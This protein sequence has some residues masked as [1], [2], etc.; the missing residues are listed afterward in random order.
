MKNDRLETALWGCY[1]SLVILVYIAFFQ[2]SAVVVVVVVVE[3]AAPNVNPRVTL[4]SASTLSGPV[5]RTLMGGEGLPNMFCLVASSL[6]R[7]RSQCS[8]RLRL[9]FAKGTKG[10]CGGVE[11]IGVG[12]QQWCVA[13]SRARQ[14]DRV[15]LVASGRAIFGPGETTI[16]LRCPRVCW[17]W[18]CKRPADEGSR[19][20]LHRRWA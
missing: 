16:H 11:E 20:D 5:V 18:I 15:R 10:V 2:T 19:V 17:W 1:L 12:F 8:Y 3:A 13:G 6:G 14:E 4:A 7:L 9:L